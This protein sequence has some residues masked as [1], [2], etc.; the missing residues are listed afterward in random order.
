MTHKEELM[1]NIQIALEKLNGLDEVKE[2]RELTDIEKGIYDEAMTELRV[3]A[4]EYGEKYL[5]T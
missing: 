4:G 3:N 5:G 2:R 1:Q